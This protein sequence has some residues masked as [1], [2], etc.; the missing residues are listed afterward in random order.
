MKLGDEE[1]EVSAGDT[2]VIRTGHA[3]QALEHGHRAAEAPVLLR[4]PVF[5]RGHVFVR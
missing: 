2:V 4:A 5:A 3:A 1:A